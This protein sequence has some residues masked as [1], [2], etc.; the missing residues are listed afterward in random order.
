MELTYM[1]I[2]TGQVIKPSTYWMLQATRYNEHTTASEKEEFLAM[3]GVSA[4]RVWIA[5]N[6][7]TEWK[8][9]N[10]TVSEESLIKP[11]MIVPESILSVEPVYEEPP[12]IEP[13]PVVI[14]ERLEIQP[15][16]EQP[17]VEPYAKPVEKK[18]KFPSKK[19]K[20]I[21]T[22]LSVP[23]SRKKREEVVHSEEPAMETTLPAQMEDPIPESPVDLAKD[24]KEQA[25]VESDH[26]EPPAPSFCPLDEQKIPMPP[27]RPKALKTVPAPPSRP[28][29]VRE[30]TL[31][32]LR[33]KSTAEASKFGRT[34]PATTVN[35]YSKEDLWRMAKTDPYYDET[36]TEDNGVVIRESRFNLKL[37][38]VVVACLIIVVGGAISIALIL[39]R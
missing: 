4:L 18:E 32:P 33:P 16:L 34:T 15:V 8:E 31:P 3:Y 11:K 39:S 21:L 9:Q 19:R 35:T 38:L 23:F 1:S 27:K 7:E 17:S 24:L 20:S 22:A 2:V 30:N 26:Q 12:V 28:H 5:M 29:T 6:P 36:A 37:T 10:T 14:E 13:Q 25:P